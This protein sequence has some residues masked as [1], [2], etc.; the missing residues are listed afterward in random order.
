MGQDTLE[1][2]HVAMAVNVSNAYER[3]FG[4]SK[5]VAH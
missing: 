4:A 1:L 2:A 5:K 3:I